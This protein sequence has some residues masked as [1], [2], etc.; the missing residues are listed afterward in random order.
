MSAPSGFIKLGAVP[1]SGSVI[2]QILFGNYISIRGWD[3]W[4]GE[5]NPRWSRENG[6][7]AGKQHINHTR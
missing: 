6:S 5:L 1:K 2:A 7:F 3:W 4:V